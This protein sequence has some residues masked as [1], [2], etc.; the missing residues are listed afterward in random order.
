MRILDGSPY[1]IATVVWHTW[2]W[3]NVWVVAIRGDGDPFGGHDPDATWP[4]IAAADWPATREH[5]LGTL[6]QATELAATQDPDRITWEKQTVAQNL[7]QIV[8]H[9]AYHIGQ[10]ALI[11]Q[12]LG[13]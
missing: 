11:R 5:L 10:I 2:F 8:V 12:E 6:R 1:S 9:S 7:L 4:V 13:L 3:V